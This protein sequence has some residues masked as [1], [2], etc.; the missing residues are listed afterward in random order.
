[1]LQHLAQE[2]IFA[3]KDPVTGNYQTVTSF[4][5]TIFGKFE[6]LVPN[7]ASG[8]AHGSQTIKPVRGKFDE[9][10]SDVQKFCDFLHRVVASQASCVTECNVISMAIAIL[11]SK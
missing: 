3:S 8:R 4:N 6:S 1:M 7:G 2:W 5:S 9:V 10:S 11:L